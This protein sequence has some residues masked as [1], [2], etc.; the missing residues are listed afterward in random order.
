MKI[1]ILGAGQVGYSIAERL[2]LPENHIT[3][4]DNDEQKLARIEERLDIRTILGH[5][6][7][8]HVL[9]MAEAQNADMLIAVTNV[10][11]VNIVAC[12]VVHSLFDLKIKIARIRD[13]SFLN[14]RRKPILFQ[15]ENISIDYVIS[16]EVEI[17]KTISKGIKAGG[18]S[19]IVDV[20]EEVK[21]INLKCEERSPILNT[22]IRL[23]LSI[24]PTINVV[25]VAIQ[26]KEK[27]FIPNAD[28]VIQLGDNVSVIMLER[29]L[30]EVIAIFGYSEPAPKNVIIAGGG[31]IGQVLAQ[32]IEANLPDVA[33]KIIDLDPIRLDNISRFLKRTEFLVGDICDIDILEEIWVGEC[34]TF[35][36]VTNNDRVNI[37]AVL[38]AKYLGVPRVTTLLSNQ[39]FAPFA[40]SLGIN[41]IVDPNAITVSTVLRYTKP[42]KISSLFSIA[43]KVDVLEVEVD[44]TSNVIGLITTEDMKIPGQVFIAAIKRGGELFLF[45]ENMAVLAEDKLVIV[46][47]AESVYKVE[48]IIMSK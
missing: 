4:V 20:F 21:L 36:S 15:E 29:Q 13:Q 27:I 42:K 22:P 11:E 8:P 32:E 43:G 7:H 38:L 28:D 12:E 24:F 44:G 3:I 10:D 23:L 33:L 45:P 26:R 5:A 39:K 1:L 35:V 14:E 48:R 2:A 41:S 46:A 47:T 16:P 37:L 17:A 9:E 25:I 30:N 19:H 40:E 34:D 31:N 18:L 6:A